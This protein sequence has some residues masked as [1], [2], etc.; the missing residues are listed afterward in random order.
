MHWRKLLAPAVIAAAVTLGGSSVAGASNIGGLGSYRPFVA[1]ATETA[2][3]TATATETST[4]TAT[5]TSTATATATAT[6]TATAT[7]TGTATATPTSTP[8]TWVKTPEEACVGTLTNPALAVL[9]PLWQGNTLPERQQEMLGKLIVRIENQGLTP[10]RHDHDDD[11][12]DDRGRHRGDLTRAEKL[13]ED[14]RKFVEKHPEQDNPHALFCR[15]VVERAANVTATATATVTPFTS[16][17]IIEQRKQ[18][19]RARIAQQEKAKRIEFEQRGRS[20]QA[21]GKH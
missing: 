17:A 18:E 10:P 12:D 14:C 15:E 2:T 6:S 16:T 11:K 7:A 13:V 21:G 8:G 1:Q 3:A 19:L 5:A 4:A 20:S 9:C